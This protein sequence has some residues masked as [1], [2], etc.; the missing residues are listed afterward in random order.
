MQFEGQND[1]AT[2][3]T[4]GNQLNLENFDSNI[5]HSKM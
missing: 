5:L 1:K 2:N 3:S 4:S